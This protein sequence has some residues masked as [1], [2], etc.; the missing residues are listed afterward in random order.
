[1]VKLRR[2]FAWS[3]VGNLGYNLTQWLLVVALARLGT[4]SMVGQFALAQAISGP[5]F[6]M[7]GLN[8]RAVRST[9]VKRVWSPDQYRLLRFGLNV[10]SLLVTIGVGLAIGMRGTALTVLVIIAM[11]KSAE[12]TSLLMYGYFQIRLRLD[13]VSRSFL[14]RAG[15]GAAGFIGA[16]VATGGLPEACLGMLAGWVLVYLLHDA[17][18]E[19]RLLRDDVAFADRVDRSATVAQLARTAFPLGLDAGVGSLANNV[20]RYSIQ[21]Q[22]GT[23]ALGTYAALAYLGQVATMLTGAMADALIGRLAI[24]ADRRDASAFKRSMTILLVFGMGVSGVIILG[25]WAFGAQVIGLLLGDAYVNQPLLIWLVVAAA[26]TTLQRCLGRG[27]QATH[28]YT[29]VLG[30]DTV[31]LVVS[32]LTVPVLVSA[33]GTPGAGAG[34]A[35]AFLIGAFPAA[36]ILVREVGRM[37]QNAPAATSSMGG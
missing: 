34:V 20:P 33:W 31:T 16:L 25:A 15:L 4:S 23:A 18:L 35:L 2:N 24:E 30:V 36:W 37:R 21:A 27:L 7:V 11:A 6:L 32:L 8:L 17:P 28:R 5:I 10:L 22:L 26:M 29:A 3:L 19:R 1:M 12:A 14:L 9:D 13:L